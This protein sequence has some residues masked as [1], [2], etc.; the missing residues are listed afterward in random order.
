MHAPVK[1]DARRNSSSMRL[2]SVPVHL[3]KVALRRHN[4][5]AAALQRLRNVRGHTCPLAAHVA[6]IADRLHLV[7]VQAR[8]IRLGGAVLEPIEATAIHVRAR[9]LRRWKVVDESY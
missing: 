4:L 1:Y 9:G 8:Q 7:G 6:A 5:A 2:S 3:L